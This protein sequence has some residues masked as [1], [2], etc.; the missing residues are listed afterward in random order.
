VTKAEQS[1]PPRASDPLDD[2]EAIACDISAIPEDER[3]AHFA[4]AR[5]LF[6]GAIAV[7]EVDAG[8]A[9]DLRPDRLADVAAFVEN[10]RR[11]CSHLAFALEIPARHGA[12]TLRITGP[13]AREEM[14]ALVD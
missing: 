9:F 12:I 13:G 7:R 6:S 8:M 1:A 5:A 11:C 10:E 2:G 14:A 4:L 3:A